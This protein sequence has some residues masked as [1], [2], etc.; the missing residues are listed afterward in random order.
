[1]GYGPIHQSGHAIERDSRLLYTLVS[2]K[3]VIVPVHGNAEQVEANARIADSLGIAT[4]PFDRNGA[5]VRVTH[6]GVDVIGYEDVKR[7]GARQIEGEVK[8][9]PRSPRGQGRGSRPPPQAYCY[10]EL[11][12]QGRTVLVADVHPLDTPT[13][14]APQAR[15]AAA[16]AANRRHAHAR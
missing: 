4:L 2:P 10:D 15:A 7:I 8:A 6:D 1:M 5:V 16:R 11:D 9:L 3:H 14:P 13:R 12:A